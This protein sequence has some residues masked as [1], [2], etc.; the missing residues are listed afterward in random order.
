[1]ALKEQILDRAQ[2]YVL[3]GN[4]DKALGEYKAAFELD[5]RDIS[6]R[7]KIGDLF[8]KSGKKT[9]AIKEYTEVAK[10][11]A[12]R[13]FYLKAIAVYKQALKLDIS[14]MEI[15]YK[16]AD[17][18]VK[19][20]LIADAISAYS[21]ILSV[22]EKKG[23]TN[24]VLEIVKKMVEVD[25]DN[26][27][28]RL[29]LADLYQ[30]MSFDKDALEEYS[31]IFE[32][33]LLQG[34]FDVAEKI[35]I[36][37]YNNNPKEVLVIK[38]LSDLYEKKGDSREHLRFS[39][40]LFNI[41]RENGDIEGAKEI[42]SSILGMK[43]EDPD[44][45]RFMAQ[46]RPVEEKRVSPPP[47][48]EPTAAQPTIAEPPGPM[49]SEPVIE[50]PSIEEASVQEREAAAPEEQ[51]EGPLI[52]LPEDIEITLEGFEE[53]EEAQRADMEGAG[54]AR[55]VEEAGEGGGLDIREAFLKGPV[56][57]T[58]E[59][60]HAEEPA[61]AEVEIELPVDIYLTPETGEPE[62]EITL[63]VE[64]AAP[65][66]APEPAVSEQIELE[67]EAAP[68]VVP[69]P[70]VS[71][72]IE[73]EVEAAPEVVPEPAVSEQIELEVEAAPEAA[74]EPAVSEQIEL[75]V[76]AAP[77]VAPEP[78][79][80]E[81]IELEAQAPVEAAQEAV[82]AEKAIEEAIE[83]AFEQTF[84]EHA[85]AA[86]PEAPVVAEEAVPE[87]EPIEEALPAPAAFKGEEFAGEEITEEEMESEQ[88][89]SAIDDINRGLEAVVEREAEIAHEA[90]LREQG[91]A[92]ETFATDAGAHQEPLTLEGLSGFA[93]GARGDMVSAEAL[94]D[95]GPERPR[96]EEP[97]AEARREEYVDLS[98]EL[99]MEEALHELSGTW[100]EGEPEEMVTEFKK[101]MGEQLGKE[102]TETH[103]N[104]GIAYMEM[105]LF[106]EASM[107]FKI[108]LKEQRLEFDCYARL[109]LCAMHQSNPDEAIV[110]YLKG[111]KV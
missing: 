62:A 14:N 28:V 54:R 35:Y 32:K 46:F 10:A 79:V 30:K 31:F 17:L 101:G 78:A 90:A 73:L 104:L 84:G 93:T 36:G 91:A 58:G 57:E 65:E 108:A 26:I 80:S 50:G 60:G 3:K 61:G 88:I 7:L 68:E 95:S 2:K 53:G 72:Q 29:K 64:E 39:K 89:S 41:Y 92:Q 75:E 40:T 22:F 94:I 69:E 106:N 11:N 34:K 76:E 21:Y 109:G 81:Q 86:P 18:Y 59:S 66:V 13:G 1:M 44:A 43:P 24:E 74:P 63:K 97:Q 49:V 56:A 48:P 107:E 111:L 8:V 27:G 5:P 16:L 102:D 38:G 85:E 45:L 33:L 100:G 25:S 37:L 103:Y 19:Q 67:V 87:Q 9:E 105:G 23:K 99:G 52:S 83:T 20:R 47:A 42:C 55:V 70:A 98:A 82:E 77:E 110:Y 12:Q 6:V 51:A 71:E 15:H 4:L 96:I